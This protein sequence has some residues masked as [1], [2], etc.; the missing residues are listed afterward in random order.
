MY[1][2]RNA[3]WVQAHRGFESHPLR[4]FLFEVLAVLGRPF[5][6][7]NPVVFEVSPS[8]SAMVPDARGMRRCASRTYGFPG[9]SG[10]SA[11]ASRPNYNLLRR[12]ELLDAMDHTRESCGFPAEK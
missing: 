5:G 6:L 12:A 3:A 2:T 9:C 11:C 10:L 8:L 4:Q 1:R 7:A